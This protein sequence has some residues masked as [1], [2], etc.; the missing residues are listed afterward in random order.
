MIGLDT[1]VLVRYI[2]QDDTK[3]SA[4]A[5]DLIQTL[6]V[7]APGFITQVALVELVWVMQRCYQTDRQALYTILD[8][9]LR[10]PELM[11][12]NAEAAL[13]ALHVFGKTN[14][15]FSDCLIA[16]CAQMAGCAYT[17]SFD[18]NAV[19]AAGMRMVGG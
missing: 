10:T 15:D 17:V 4:I 1:N 14:A 8:M 2:A 16:Q 12:E 13:K 18:K 6:T 3:Q 9:L 7:D 11:V 5:N 19:K